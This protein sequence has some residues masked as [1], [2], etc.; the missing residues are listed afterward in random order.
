[1]NGKQQPKK[2]GAQPRPAAQA[3]G[4]HLAVRKRPGQA[5]WELVP[6]RCAQQRR[7]D[8]EEVQKMIDAG[9]LEVAVDELRWLL[10]GCSDCLA[11]H[12]MLGELAL[13]SRDLPLARAHFGYVVQAVTQTLRRAKCAGPLPYRLPANQV[14]YESG[15]GLAHCFRELAKPEL[16]RELIAELLHWDPTDPLGLQGMAA[17]LP[18]SGEPATG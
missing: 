7:E 3:S 18:P 1:M 12:R 15:K 14:F 10:Q 8:L 17:G 16:C 2:P 5:A 6:P 13:V 11:A 9:E 4:A